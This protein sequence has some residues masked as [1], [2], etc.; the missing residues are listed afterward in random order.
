MVHYMVMDEACGFLLNEVKFVALVIEYLGKI[1][2]VRDGLGLDCL[3]VVGCSFSR[4]RFSNVT[5]Q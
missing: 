1:F 2:R 3:M 5:L 4:T